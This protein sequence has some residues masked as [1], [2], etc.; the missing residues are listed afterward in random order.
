MLGNCG[1]IAFVSWVE[2]GKK[3]KTFPNS[4]SNILEGNVLTSYTT[5]EKNK[6]VKT[7]GS[8]FYFLCGGTNNTGQQAILCKARLT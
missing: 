2:G 7:P 3:K 5:V 1:T 8:S 4:S 6:K